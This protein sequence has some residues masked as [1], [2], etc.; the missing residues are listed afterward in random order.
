M[1]VLRFKPGR[2]EEVLGLSLR[3]ALEVMERLKIEVEIDREGYVVAELEVDRPDMYSLEGI[4]RQVNGILERELGLPRYSVVDTDYV[5]EADDVPTR[6]YIVGLV[7]WD[8]DIDEDYLVE[9]I[10]FQEKLTTSHGLGRR[11]IA[12]GIHD[13]EKMPSKHLMYRFEHID[14]V[15][16]KPL[17]TG[18]LMKLRDVLRE[19]EQGARYGTISLMDEKHPVLYAGDEV[20]SV[21]PVI[22]ADVTRIEPGTRHVFVD[23]TGT[24]LKPVL[25]VAA[26]FAANLAERSKSR[27]I[28]LV[29][30]KAPWGELKEPKLEPRKTSITTSTVNSILGLNLS[31]DELARHLQRM[32]FDALPLSNT[33]IDV[34]VPRFR[35]DI[36]HEADLAEEVALSIGLE[37]I[38]PIKPRTMLRGRLL[39]IRYWEREARAI[40]VGYGFVEV[41]TYTLTSCENQEKIVGIERE[42][43]ITISNPVSIEANCFRASMIPA[44]LRLASR[45]QHLVPLKIFEL[46]E[47]LEKKEAIKVPGVAPVKAKKLITL[48]MMDE[49]IGYE[50]IQAIVYGL[51][52]LLSDKISEVDRVE[53]PF[54]IKGRSALIKTEKGLRIIIGEVNPA[55]LELLEIKYPVVIAEIDYSSLY[56]KEVSYQGGAAVPRP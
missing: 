27:R 23:I 11:R 13:L 26:I 42:K 37:N 7:V 46:G 18:R 40:L 34:M 16:F 51:V 48:L 2:V 55:L 21:P 24:E 20:I 32:R 35:I 17:H 8:V 39:G 22:N 38:A 52:K 9:L 3:K 41:K 4:A 25:D 36:L 15:V 43:L 44:L 31:G 1:P 54:L 14:S 45:N 53:K 50:D 49:K 6:P 33:K 10:Q 29:T 47:A 5:I 12:V 56:D 28:G 30:V 19:L